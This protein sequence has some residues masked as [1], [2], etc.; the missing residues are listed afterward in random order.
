MK[1]IKIDVV[2]QEIY[3]V[4]IPKGVNELKSIYK[5]LGVTMIEAGLVL[6]NNDYVFV[7]EE[8]LLKEPE[9][10][11]GGFDI[12]GQRQ[13]LLGHGLVMGCG[14]DGDS[15]DVKSTVEEIKSRVVFIPKA[16]AKHLVYHE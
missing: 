8:G 16:V 12:T 10:V 3:E 2:K 11:I 4:E 13:H 9:D 5:E 14:R 6:P 7:D 15:C 1:A